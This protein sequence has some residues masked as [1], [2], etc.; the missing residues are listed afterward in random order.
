MALM[1]IDTLDLDSIIIKSKVPDTDIVSDTLAPTSTNFN[2]KEEIIR[3]APEELI[4]IY[5]SGD[6]DY[7]VIGSIIINT[8]REIM[9]AKEYLLMDMILEEGYQKGITN[10]KKSLL[11]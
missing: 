2:I 7:N 11:T 6:I 1:G 9:H 10:T 4:E 3:L 5:L 8:T